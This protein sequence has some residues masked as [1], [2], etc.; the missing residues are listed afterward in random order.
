[1]AVSEDT[2]SPLTLDTATQAFASLL[3]APEELKDRET[4]PAQTPEPAPP[5]PP[6]SEAE[7]ADGES[8]SEQNPDEPTE[9]PATDTLDP[10]TKLKLKIDGKDEEVT[11]DEALKG[12]SRTQDYTRKTQE[13]AER[14]KAFDAEEAAVRAERAQTAQYL[15]QLE[16]VITEVTPKEPDWDKLRQENPV[17]F[18]A[19][20]AQWD[21]YA[22]ELNVVRQQRAEAESKLVQD[23]ARQQQLH[24]EAEKQRLFESIPEW[25]DAEIAKADKTRLTTYANSLGFDDERLAQVDD[26][27]V[28]VMLRKAMQW[29]ELQAKKPAMQA[30]IEKVKTATPGPAGG[31]K[32]PVTEA[33]RALQRLA[34]TG[35]QD[36]AAAAFLSMLG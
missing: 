34:K 29:D 30:R 3:S 18:A 13:L 1:M 28:L 36:D 8:E 20:W 24:L 7:P 15:R 33:T 9:N 35:K 16:Q 2:G 27:R 6:A 11:L 31:G 26:H 21:Q 5:E 10:A 14:R 4:P 25:K 12:Y 23:A 19:Q 32:A 17:E 22:R